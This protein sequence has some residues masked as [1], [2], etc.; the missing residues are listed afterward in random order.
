MSGRLRCE[1]AH[2]PRYQL[3]IWTCA[4]H[5][6]IWRTIPDNA[7]S[8]QHDDP[9]EITQRRKP[10]SDCYDGTSPHQAP[11]RVADRFLRF[12]VERRSRF[13]EQQDRGILQ[14]CARN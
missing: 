12:T 14:K 6:T 4:L 8:L 13:I 11:E 5:Q 9:I 3:S 10:V 7:T 2:L 1:A